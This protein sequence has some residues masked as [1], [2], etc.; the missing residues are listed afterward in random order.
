MRDGTI[1]TGE[2]LEI[3]DDHLVVV[4]S[5]E[6]G[7][8]D[9]ASPDVGMTRL[10]TQTTRS[11]K[12]TNQS[13]DATSMDP[14]SPDFR[15]TQSWMTKLKKQAMSPAAFRGPEHAS[16]LNQIKPSVQRA[17]LSPKTP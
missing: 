4:Q 5:P 6:P 11:K 2:S 15:E 9:G 10:T 7:L 13:F 12:N 1:A 16:A 8:D 3:C 14:A 17:V